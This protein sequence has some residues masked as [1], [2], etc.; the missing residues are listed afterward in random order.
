MSTK[1]VCVRLFRGVRLSCDVMDCQAP[2]SMDFPSK[3][4]LIQGIFPT[5]GSNPS[6]ALQVDSLSLC[7][8]GS[9][10]KLTYM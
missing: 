4:F 6:P 8:L 7:H 2:L 1:L 5:Q 9:P 3:N 10:V